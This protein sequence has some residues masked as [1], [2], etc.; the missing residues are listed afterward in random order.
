M[1]SRLDEYRGY[2]WQAWARCIIIRMPLMLPL[3]LVTVAGDGA[4]RLLDWLQGVLPPG[5]RDV[6]K[7]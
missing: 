5:L 2:R 7:V 1:A 3:A 4:A 6:D